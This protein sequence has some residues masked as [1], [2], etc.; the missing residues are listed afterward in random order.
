MDRAAI[1]RQAAEIVRSRRQPV[2]LAT[3]LY[4]AIIL[5]FSLLSY[6]LTM[7]PAEKLLQI[8]SLASLGDYE[9]ALDL[10]NANQPAF[11][12]TLM[13]DLLSYLE[14]IVSFG[15]LMLLLNA[16]RGKEIAPA[17]LLDGFGYWIPVLLLSILSRFLISA[18][19]M[20]LIVPGIIAMYSYRMA[21]YLLYTRPK[22]GVLGCMRES[23]IRMRG[24]RMELFLLDLS[25]LG[26]ALLSC[27]PV[28][29]LVAAFWFLPRWG[30]ASLLYY[31]AISAPYDAAPTPPDEGASSF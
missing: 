24:H 9:G 10:A 18:L 14:T 4:L 21:R 13:S 28:I 8:G 20:L 6:Q 26:W 31:E 2:L 12:E 22:L 25:Y 7:P 17:M 30:C 23:R 1:K 19:L 11:R 5:L 29:G 27:L 16:V 3:G 15:Y